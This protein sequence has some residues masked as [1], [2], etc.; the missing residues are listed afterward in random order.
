MAAGGG[1]RGLTT[2]HWATTH[3]DERSILIPAACLAYRANLDKSP[4][5]RVAVG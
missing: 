4:R 1:A 2:L 3:R 5:Q